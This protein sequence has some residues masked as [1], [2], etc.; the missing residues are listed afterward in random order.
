MIPAFVMLASFLFA[1]DTAQPVT[2]VPAAQISPAATAAG[3]GL[4]GQAQAVTLTVGATGVTPGNLTATASNLRVFLGWDASDKK[5]TVYNI[6]RSTDAGNYYLKINKEEIKENKFIDDKKNSVTPP[7]DGSRYYYKVSSVDAGKETGASNIAAVEVKVRFSPPDD[8]AVVPELS[9]VTLKWQIPD[10]GGKAV[11]DGYNIFRS[12]DPGSPGEMINPELV[13]DTKYVDVGNAGVPLQNGRVYYYR[14]QSVDSTGN[15]SNLSVPAAAMPYS[16]ASPPVG[17]TVT[18]ASTESIKILW[19]EPK[20]PGTYGVSA[21][22]VFRSVAPDSFPAE[23]INLRPVKRYYDEQGNVF[24]FDNILNSKTQPEIGTDYYY[25][26]E[27]VDTLGNTG[28]PS[29]TVKAKIEIIELK[30]SGIITAELSDYGLPPESSLTISGLKWIK[31]Q[32]SAVWPKNAMAVLVKNG[33]DI[34][35]G[36]RVKLQGTIGKKI[37]VDV[38]YDDTILTDEQRKIFIKYEGE[39]GETLQEASFGDITL[40]LPPTKYVSFTQSLFGVKAK[41]KFGDKLTVTGIGAQSKGIP[42]KQQ[43]IGNL[44]EREENGLKGKEIFDTDFIANQY[45]YLTKDTSVQIKP[46]SVV[47]Y[48]YAFVTYEDPNTIRSNPTGKYK[49]KIRTLGID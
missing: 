18:A 49:Y 7:V 26:V 36:L 1:Q 29:E 22:N 45:F 11:I 24:Y 19:K 8:I 6:Y 40:D 2:L 27:P 25:K 15:T 32:Y 30:K 4:A 13:T 31:M 47:V 23:P 14:L 38:D 21:Y 10:S 37:T 41:V 33:F 46:G 3:G 20:D 9:K 28:T 34:T 44:R 39:K 12:I 48:V 42:A 5:N 35:Q 43:F 16:R 17:L